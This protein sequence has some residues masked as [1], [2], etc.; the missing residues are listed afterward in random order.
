MYNFE[1][2]L[3]WFYWAHKHA[4]DV[5]ILSISVLPPLLNKMSIFFKVET[6]PSEINN[7]CSYLFAQQHS[8]QCED[9]LSPSTHYFSHIWENVDIYCGSPS[10]KE[11]NL[12]VEIYFCIVQPNYFMHDFGIKNFTIYISHRAVLDSLTMQMMVVF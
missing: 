12:P 4:A 5:H 7:Y 10:E 6:L 8:L 1:E 3:V 2:Q 11:K 9:D